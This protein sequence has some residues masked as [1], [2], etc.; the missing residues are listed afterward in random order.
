MMLLPVRRTPWRG[1]RSPHTFVAADARRNAAARTRVGGAPHDRDGGQPL[2]AIGGHPLPRIAARG[3][4]GTVDRRWVCLATLGPIGVASLVYVVVVRG[5]I[6]GD[7]DH[8]ARLAAARRPADVRVR[9]V[10]AHGDVVAIRGVH[11]AR[12]RPR[13]RS[14]RRTRPSCSATSS[15]IVGTVV[16]ALQHDRTDR[17]CGG[18]RGVPDRVRHVPRPGSPSGGGSGSRSASSGCRCS[19]A[20][21]RCSRPRT[22]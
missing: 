15:C 7:A 12:P 20:R 6:E 22:W 19:S 13:W 11:R 4:H 14:A 16:P 3:G 21:S 9:H 10:A 18:D 2:R 17:G 8:G 5:F 1:I